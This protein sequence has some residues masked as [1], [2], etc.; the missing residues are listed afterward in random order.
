M[1]IPEP[2]MSAPAV[3]I[4]QPSPQMASLLWIVVS[5][6]GAVIAALIG[7]QIRVLL[8]LGPASVGHDSAYAATVVGGVIAAGSQ[9]LVL[10]RYRLDV[11]WWV[12]ATVVADLI[13]MIIVEP[14]VLNR[15]I[16][17]PNTTPSMGM[18]VLGGALTLGAAGLVAGIAQALVL[19]PS[20]GDIALAWIPATL[21]GGA[22]AGVFTTILAGSF[23]ALPYVMALSAITALGALLT[24]A[25]QVPVFLRVL[26]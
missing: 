25:S 6:T 15:F 26:R 18:I 14:S 12:P 10:R 20:S 24:A 1:A 4:R 22:L 3:T 2:S 16:P 11:Y 23:F 21:I 13:N 7:W 17:A 19:R 5:V 9:W 8:G